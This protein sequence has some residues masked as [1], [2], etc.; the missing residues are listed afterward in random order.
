MKGNGKRSR[1][2]S[3]QSSHVAETKKS[4]PGKNILLN[5]HSMSH[6]VEKIY[7]E[8]KIERGIDMLH[9][10]ELNVPVRHTPQYPLTKKRKKIKS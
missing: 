4:K 6:G 2:K 10:N 5:C 8:M 1:K 7:R 9:F 3:A